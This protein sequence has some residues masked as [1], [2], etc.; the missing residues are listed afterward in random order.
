MPKATSPSYTLT[1][2][3]DIN[4]KI[5]M[6]AKV[7]S[8]IAKKGGDIGSID[9]VRVTQDVAERDFTIYARDEKHAQGIIDSVKKIQGVKVVSVSDA[10]MHMHLGGKI[11]VENKM[12]LNSRAALSMAYTPGVARVC[13]AINKDKK[14]LIN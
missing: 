9:I 12:P 8:M 10:V 5:G 13:M 7:T 6:L 2:R 14:E 1:M 3:L 4:Y 11:S